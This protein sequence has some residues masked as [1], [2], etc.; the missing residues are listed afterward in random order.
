MV[1]AS[2]VK[3]KISPVI[4]DLPKVYDTVKLTCVNCPLALYIFVDVMLYLEVFP[5]VNTSVG[6][7]GK[8]PPLVGTTACVKTTKVSLKSPDP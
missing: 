5:T 7:V 2:A 6:S 1:T 4:D 8:Y 3:V